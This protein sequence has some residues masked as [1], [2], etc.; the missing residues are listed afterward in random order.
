MDATDLL[1]WMCRSCVTHCSAKMIESKE[2]GNGM[3]CGPQ[4]YGGFGTEMA[5]A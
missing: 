5:K 2:S 4:G 3:W 1:L